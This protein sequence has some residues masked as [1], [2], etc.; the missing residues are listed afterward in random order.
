MNTSGFRVN[1]VPIP[2]ILNGQRAC[3]GPDR[4][5]QEAVVLNVQV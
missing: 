4:E 1:E 3:G 5:V 2:P